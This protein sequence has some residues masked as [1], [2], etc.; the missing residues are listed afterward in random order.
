MI[1]QRVKLYKILDKDH[2]VNFFK[3]FYNFDKYIIN[4][5]KTIYHDFELPY[6]I[7]NLVEYIE[8]YFLDIEPHIYSRQYRNKNGTLKLE[9]L[10]KDLNIFNFVNNIITSHLKKKN[11]EYV[12]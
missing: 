3:K 4:V 1:E 7:Q 8:K 9:K 12:F 11:L 6:N 5:I 10:K 2:F